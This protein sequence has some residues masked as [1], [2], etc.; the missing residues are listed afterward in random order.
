MIFA[1]TETSLF[2]LISA[3]L[4]N[5][6]KLNHK[7]QVN[8]FPKKK[9]A[10]KFSFLKKSLGREK[11]REKKKIKANTRISQ[12]IPK[13]YGVQKT[14][15]TCHYQIKLI[16]KFF[17]IMHVSICTGSVLSEIKS[18]EKPMSIKNNLPLT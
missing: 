17:N 14:Q 11:V 5:H 3:L 15:F 18:I 10:I 13:T 2:F 1:E 16:S 12:V 4:E 6:H 9:A 7:P 8:V